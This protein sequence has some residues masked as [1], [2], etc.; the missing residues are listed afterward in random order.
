MDLSY[1]ISAQRIFAQLGKELFEMRILTG[2]IINAA[3]ISTCPNTAFF[4]LNKAVNSIIRNRIG[5]TIF[6]LQ[7]YCI[8]GI[9]IVNKNARFSSDPKFIDRSLKEIPDKY[10]GLICIISEYILISIRLY[11]E[12]LCS[13]VRCTN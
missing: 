4:I 8:P 11:V 1:N 3:K 2:I 10:F 12:K 5:I 7:V 6:F 13:L 9:N